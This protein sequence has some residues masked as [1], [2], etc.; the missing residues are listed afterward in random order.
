MTKWCCNALLSELTSMNPRAART[1][2]TAQ[3]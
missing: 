3:G 1:A 2:K